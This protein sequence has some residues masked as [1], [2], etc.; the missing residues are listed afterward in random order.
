[1]DYETAVAV[2]HGGDQRFMNG[3]F[4]RHCAA[5]GRLQQFGV[6]GLEMH[7]MPGVISF[8]YWWTDLGNLILMK[9]NRIDD[10]ERQRRFQVMPPHLRRTTK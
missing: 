9:L 3:V 7:V 1:M 4:E 2:V 6:L 5:I 10:L 8:S